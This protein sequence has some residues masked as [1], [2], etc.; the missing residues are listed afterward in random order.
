MVSLWC[1]C[2]VTVVSL[3]CHCG[4]TVMY[5]SVLCCR[6]IKLSPGMIIDCDSSVS[7]L[8]QLTNAA[9]FA[10]FSVFPTDSAGKTN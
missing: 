9:G 6:E 2:G 3:W 8:A 10:R 7:V 5:L 4:V 1:H